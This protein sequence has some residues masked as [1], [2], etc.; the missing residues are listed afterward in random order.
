DLFYSL[1]VLSS[2]GATSAGSAAVFETSLP[3]LDTFTQMAAL[4]VANNTDNLPGWI[5][6]NI[7]QPQGTQVADLG[8]AYTDAAGE[9]ATGAWNISRDEGKLVAQHINGV[10]TKKGTV[11][12]SICT[13]S[14]LNY[15]GGYGYCTPILGDAGTA[16]LAAHL[17]LGVSADGSHVAY[18]NGTL[19]IAGIG[20]DHEAKLTKAGWTTPPAWAD[21]KT[22]TATQLASSSTDANGVIHNDTNIL[23]FSGGSAGATFISGGSN[24]SWYYGG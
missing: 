18:T 2:P 22:V 4:D 9:L 13:S 5:F 21:D 1:I 7:T 23:T 17:E 11:S 20:G 14:S 10:D 15:L 19:Y 24:P 3:S 6:Q 16:S 12:S 8:T